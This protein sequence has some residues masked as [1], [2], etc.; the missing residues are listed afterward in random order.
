MFEENIKKNFEIIDKIYST[1]EEKLGQSTEEL[2]EKLNNIDMQ[3]IKDKISKYIEDKEKIEEIVE[4]LN[5]LE[6]D[7]EIKM[8]TY[9]KES[10]K[11][12]FKDAFELFVECLQ[13]QLIF[14]YLIAL[15]NKL[16]YN[17]VNS[18]FS[19]RRKK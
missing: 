14:Y 7:Y 4:K 10:Y 15:N 1:R 16:I 13:A 12:G 9:M 18:F 3:D 19:K 6:E 17:S 2:K 11:Q 8:A 5:L